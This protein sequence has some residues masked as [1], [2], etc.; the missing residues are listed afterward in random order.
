MSTRP[1][2]SSLWRWPTA[3]LPV[4]QWKLV[5]RS[6]ETTL[7]DLKAPLELAN[8]CVHQA[9]VGRNSRTSMAGL[10]RGSCCF[11]KPTWLCMWSLWT[12]TPTLR[13][14]VWV[15]QSDF[16]PVE[17]LWNESKTSTLQRYPKTVDE[18]AK[19]PPQWCGRL[20]HCY[21]KSLFLIPGVHFLFPLF[22]YQM[23]VFMIVW[24]W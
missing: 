4:A 22:E 13:W 19:I 5:S 23:S 9:T 6:K 24:E 10:H 16:S 12:S 17:M 1:Q 14:T 2:K 8:V 18:W 3:T 7:K 11:L 20:I 15:E 21:K